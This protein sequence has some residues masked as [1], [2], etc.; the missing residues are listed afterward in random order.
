MKNGEKI[1]QKIANNVIRITKNG[2][3]C[4]YWIMH[5]PKRP[6]ALQN[7]PESSK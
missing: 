7:K 3:L 1:K 2:P 6:K 4:A 5:Q